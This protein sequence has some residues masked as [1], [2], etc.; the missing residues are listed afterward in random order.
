MPLHAAWGSTYDSTHGWVMAG[1]NTNYTEHLMQNTTDG[2]TF[3]IVGPLP[4]IPS[5]MYRHEEYPCLESLHNGGDI[6]LTGEAL[7][8]TYIFRSNSSTWERQP[9]I[10]IPVELFNCD[11]YYWECGLGK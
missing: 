11:G 10:P 4:F 7:N 5:P 9:D 1:H 2:T 6:F 3:G 8:S